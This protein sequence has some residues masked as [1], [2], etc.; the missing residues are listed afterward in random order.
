MHLHLSWEAAYFKSDSIQIRFM[1][2]TIEIQKFMLHFLHILLNLY[3]FA[4]LNILSI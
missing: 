3:D 1:D 4:Y 2:H